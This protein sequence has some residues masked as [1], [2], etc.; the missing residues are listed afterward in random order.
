MPW[1]YPA[2]RLLGFPGRNRAGMQETL[3]RLDAQVAAAS[4]P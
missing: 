4:R 2:L 1:V 3:Q